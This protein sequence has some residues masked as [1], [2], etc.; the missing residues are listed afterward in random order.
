MTDMEVSLLPKDGNFDAV[1]LEIFYDGDNI[2][3]EMHDIEFSGDAAIHDPESGANEKVE[4]S[5]PLSVAK[6]EILASTSERDSGLK[7]PN[8]KI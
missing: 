7:M 3:L 4:F 2:L 5:G 8:F 6:I 1:D